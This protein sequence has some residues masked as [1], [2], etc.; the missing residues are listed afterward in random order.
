MINAAKETVTNG[1]LIMIKIRSWLL[2]S[3]FLCFCISIFPLSFFSYSLDPCY[4][5]DANLFLAMQ[6]TQ[7]FYKYIDNSDY[8]EHLVLSDQDCIPLP[9]DWHLTNYEFVHVRSSRQK[10]PSCVWYML[11][12]AKAIQTIVQKC[13]HLSAGMIKGY[14]D[15]KLVP[16]IQSNEDSIKKHL[17]VDTLFAGLK[18]YQ[19]PLLASYL[20]I[21]NYYDIYMSRESDGFFVS[22]DTSC[23]VLSQ[24]VYIPSGFPDKYFVSDVNALLQSIKKNNAPIVHIFLTIPSSGTISHAVLLTIIHRPHKKPLLLYLNSNGNSLCKTDKDNAANN[25]LSYITRFVKS[26]DTA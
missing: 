22:T 5:Q 8:F 11:L 20:G 3:F 26:L 9:L 2:L 1:R 24:Q 12:N 7:S 17:Q 21:K 25:E 14:I 10:G 16:F 18:I 4:I 23:A 19:T 15:I 6:C 13:A